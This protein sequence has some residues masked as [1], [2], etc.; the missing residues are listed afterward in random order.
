MVAYAYKTT[1][2]SGTKEV[3]KLSGSPTMHQCEVSELFRN[4][5][6][7]SSQISIG[8]DEN[9]I[10][11]RGRVIHDLVRSVIKGESLK[12]KK[13]MVGYINRLIKEEDDNG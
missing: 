3:L 1:Y 6:V 4:G 13:A 5:D 11:L 7:Y 12:T 2:V 9:Y 8:D 10:L